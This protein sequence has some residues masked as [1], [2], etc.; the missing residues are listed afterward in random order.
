M[1][2]I[3]RTGD[4]SRTGD[5]IEKRLFEDDNDSP[6]ESS[7]KIESNNLQNQNDIEK[8]DQ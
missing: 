1:Q 2:I 5:V 8:H 7:N 3:N 4:I 6:K